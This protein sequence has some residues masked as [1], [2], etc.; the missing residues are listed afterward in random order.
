MPLIEGTVADGATVYTDE[1]GVYNRLSEWGYSHTSVKHRRIEYVR[2][3][4]NEETGEVRSVHTN[5]IEGFWSYIKGAYS[6]VH[7]GIDRRYL[8]RYLDEYAF[9]YSY[10]AGDWLMFLTM[11]DRAATSGLL[12]ATLPA[13][14]PR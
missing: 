1:S 6:T 8:Q 13:S 2:E 12:S 7:R 3:E 11:L 5:S 4:V 10:R 9:R 14:R